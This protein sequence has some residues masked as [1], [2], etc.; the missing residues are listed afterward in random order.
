MKKNILASIITFGGIGLISWVVYVLAS[1]PY[2][3]QMILFRVW[4]G[5]MVVLMIA[6]I[7]SL[8]RFILGD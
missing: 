7:W 2:D 8:V 3:T 6:A 1:L 5:L 4:F